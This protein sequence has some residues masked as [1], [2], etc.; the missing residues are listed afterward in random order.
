[1]KFEQQLDLKDSRA[2]EILGR[3]LALLAKK[4]DIF[5]LQ[6][7]LGA[8]KSTLARAF[9]RALTTPLEDVPSPTFTLVQFYDS[10]KGLLYHFD[11]HR[12]DHPEQAEELAVDDAFSDGI[13]LVEWPENLG[14]LMPK[15]RLWIELQAGPNPNNRRA[16]LRG[17][18]FWNERWM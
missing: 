13:S 15:R 2:T 4:G 14:S 9:I 8:G 11:L 1:M 5:A 12:L 18:D 7:P 3:R 16:I 6:G 10:A 17:Q